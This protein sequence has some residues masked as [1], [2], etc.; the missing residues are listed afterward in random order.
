[1]NYQIFINLFDE[2][3]EQGEIKNYKVCY[4][5]FKFRNSQRF[6]G[7]FI[8]DG[9]KFIS[10]VLDFAGLRV[11]SLY[12]KTDRSFNCKFPV[13]TID[14]ISLPSREDIELVKECFILPAKEWIKEDE[15]LIFDYKMDSARKPEPA[16]TA[17]ARLCLRYNLIHKI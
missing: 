8:S 12:P 9:N 17:V 4:A 6:Y 14:D 7:Y 11:Y 2:F 16:E 13:D 5:S 15:V 10:N 1:M 3:N